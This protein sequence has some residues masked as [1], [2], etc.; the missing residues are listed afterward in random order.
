MND[1]NQIGNATPSIGIAWTCAD[2]SAR[3]MNKIRYHLVI[4]VLALLAAIVLS[5]NA[6]Q[7]TADSPKG[8]RIGG[9][10]RIAGC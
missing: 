6:P 8:P 4:L 2:R 10:I 1:N 3:A 5:L 9:V 7:C